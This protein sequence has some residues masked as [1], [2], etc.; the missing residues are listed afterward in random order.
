MQIQKTS[1]I[2]ESYTI[3]NIQWVKKSQKIQLYHQVISNNVIFNLLEIL[4]LWDTFS[5]AISILNII[6]F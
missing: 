3:N 2:D 4:F 5:Y 1:P 6:S